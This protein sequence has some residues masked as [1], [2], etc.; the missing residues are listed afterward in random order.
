LSNKR[1]FKEPF[2]EEIYEL[3]QQAIELIKVVPRKQVDAIVY[4][5]E[6]RL[7]E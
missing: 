1:L 3:L 6:N 7:I 2:S 5:L 4:S